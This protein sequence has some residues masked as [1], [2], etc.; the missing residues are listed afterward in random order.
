MS[1]ADKLNYLNE[2]KEAIKTALVEKGV[3][4]SDSDTFRSYA[5]K[6]GEISSGGSGGSSTKYGLNLD[7]ILGD[8]DEN[9]VLQAPT[10]KANLNFAGVTNIGKSALNYAFKG[11]SYIDSITFPDLTKITNKNAFYGAFYESSAT[12][13]SFSILNG[14]SGE[15]ACQQMF[16]SS[17][18]LTSADLSNLSEVSGYNS[19]GSMFS[20]CYKLEYVNI[21]NLKKIKMGACQQM[22][23][24][25]NA[26][27][28][29][30]FTNLEYIAQDG[31]N[32][33]FAWCSAL[34]KVSFPK[35]T[36]LQNNSCLG[37]SSSFYI[38]NGCSALTEIH[39][40]ADMQSQIEAQLG[41]SSKF[42][43]TNATIYFDL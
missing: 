17:K 10:S 27:K 4:V 31:V 42:G 1:T 11:A 28:E 36:S 24:S 7:N 37:S 41:Y 8:V 32:S 33:M 5:D 14:I 6:I 13:V 15:F 39:F 43:A 34:S 19:C 38:F 12:S 22:F 23:Y 35:L 29:I 9:G 21:A 40:R 3:S 25:C 30:E 18:Q 26:L 2:T 16:Y 20:N